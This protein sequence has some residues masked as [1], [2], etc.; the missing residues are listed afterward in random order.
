MTNNQTTTA[1][2][3]VAYR[4]VST[5]DQKTDRQ[6][7][8]TGITFDREFADK[9]T[10]GNV[11]RPAF[12]EML[13][14]VRAG[15]T[16]H[17]HSLDRFSR[18]LADLEAT[19]KDLSS[20]GVSVRFHKE[21]ITTG[22][23]MSG[24]DT[25]LLQIIAAV[26]QFELNTIRE[27]QREGIEARKEK[28]GAKAYPGRDKNMRKR[29]EVRRCLEQGMTIRATMAHVPCSNGLVMAVKKEMAE[30]TTDRTQKGIS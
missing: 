14:Y 12:Q 15:D 4:R 3:N 22:G 1:G 16:I 17:V 26:S 10:G 9:A 7:V 25:L 8:D 30:V 27:R 28:L 11:D 23:G 13:S 5:T 6:L 18:N 24:V 29:A 20:R 21:G 19:I 2:Q